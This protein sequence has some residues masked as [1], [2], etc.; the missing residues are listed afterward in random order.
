MFLIWDSQDYCFSELNFENCFYRF[1][2]HKLSEISTFI[3]FHSVFAFFS[4][5]ANV[6]SY[7]FL[8][9]GFLGL[10]FNTFADIFSLVKYLNIVA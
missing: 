5:A 8:T 1:M 4:R 7:L 3:L 6:A 2:V 9:W 10:F